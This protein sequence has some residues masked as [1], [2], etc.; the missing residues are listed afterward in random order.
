VSSPR[1]GGSP[2]RLVSLDVF[3]G[4]TVAAMILVNDQGS[5][6]AFPTLRHA[7][8][9]GW[10]LADLVFPSFLFIVGASVVMS[11]AGRV[12]RGEPRRAL[13]VHVLRRGATLLAIGAIMN[14]VF[15]GFDFAHW[16]FEGVLQR[17][18]LCF[19]AVATLVIFTGPRARWAIFAACLVGYWIL[20][21][22]VP[23]PGYGLPGR[24][25]PLLDPDGNL[26]AW[27]DRLAFSGHLYNG[28]RDPEG[29]LS[30]IPSFATTLLGV[31]TAE[32]LRAP[33]SPRDKL[34]GLV[35]AGVAC[36]VAGEA[37]ARVFPINKNLWTSS[38]VLLTGGLS[39]LGLAAC[40]YAL[41][42]RQWRG[43][44]LRVP[45]VFGMNAMAA[46]IL[47]EGL[48]AAIDTFGEGPGG[49]PPVWQVRVYEAVFAPL[50]PP[51]LA[52]LLY[53]LAF[54]AV[55][56]VAMDVLYR[57]RIFLKI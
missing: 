7:E 29:L 43:K 30:T 56:W 52:S 27:I 40:C 11:L 35:A 31:F 50:A 33:D 34:R 5:D 12:A 49:V 4:L 19:V 17:I 22:F 13:F 36:V 10:T 53:A 44:A 21:R 51:P 42:V 57:R 14:L 24:D 46:Y 23:V 45:L 1:A 28:T 3:R 41:D 39:L 32:R 6:L 47:S 15:V 54:L 37:W 25:V 9:S 18:A 2:P 55:C 16:R 8:W 20:L 48:Q 26:T 38:F